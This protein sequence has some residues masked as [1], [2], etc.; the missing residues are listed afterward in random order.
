[1]L[2]AITCVILFLALEIVVRVFSLTSD[3]ALLFDPILGYVPRPHATVTRNMPEYTITK[4]INAD[5]FWGKWYPKE[6]QAEVTR[7]IALG[8][9][10]T[11]ARHVEDHDSYTA[12]AE[13]ELNK[14]EKKYEVVN[15]GRGGYGTRKERYVLEN[16]GLS[17]SPDIVT[18]GFF[19]GND[20]INNVSEQSIDP[21]KRLTGFPLW[22]EHAKAFAINHSASVRYVLDLKARNA[23]LGRAVTSTATSTDTAVSPEYQ[24]FLP[25]IT[26]L[27]E[28]GYARTEQEL[29]RLKALATTHKFSLLVLLFPDKIQVHKEFRLPAYKDFVYTQPQENLIATLKAHNIAYID[30]LPLFESRVAQGEL[31]FYPID[32]H[33]N[34]SGHRIVGETVA[35]YIRQQ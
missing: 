32:G 26:P 18:V 25:E 31:L 30:F 7:I 11:E 20:V 16:V 3:E 34:T 35:E 5:G 22:K 12:I 28:E 9:S 19:I 13:A 33:F 6:K 1:M 15:L 24:I 2:S 27:I 8:D 14:T 17:F 10:F 4:H 29:V 23:F 21:Q